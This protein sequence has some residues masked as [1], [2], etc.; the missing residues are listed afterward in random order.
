MVDGDGDSSCPVNCCRE[1]ENDSCNGRC[2]S[3]S[4]PAGKNLKKSDKTGKNQKKSVGS[5]SATGDCYS[6]SF[7]KGMISKKSGVK[8]PGASGKCT[9]PGG[10]CGPREEKNPVAGVC[11]VCGCTEEHACEGGCHWVDETKTLC[12]ECKEAA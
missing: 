10:L 11:R 2:A 8:I 5:D 1:C 9:R 12:S 7:H 3:A 6:C 4:M